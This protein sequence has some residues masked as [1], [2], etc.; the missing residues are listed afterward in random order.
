MSGSEM[1]RSVFDIRMY[2]PGSR[3]FSS[4]STASRVERFALL[5]VG[6]SFE[7]GDVIDRLDHHGNMSLLFQ[8]L[9]AALGL[10]RR[11]EG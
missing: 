4:R 11:P 7:I 9:E 10:L 6:R 8:P 5:F 2:I 3:I 1:S